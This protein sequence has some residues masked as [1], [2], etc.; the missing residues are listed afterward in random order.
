MNLFVIG[1]GG[2]AGEVIDALRAAPSEKMTIQGLYDDDTR[3]KGEPH[4]AKY[5]G[6]IAEFISDTPRGT[7]YIF[8]IGDNLVRNRLA[9]EFD[10]ASKVPVSVIHPASSVSAR[11]DI[12]P[13]AYVAAFAFVG[14]RAQ[15]GRHVIVNVGASVGHDAVLGDFGQLCPG[16]RV[17]G[18]CQ[19]GR[20]A[21]LGSNAVVAPRVKVGPWAKLSAGSF[22]NRDVP[23]KLFAIGVPAKVIPL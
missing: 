13:G 1:G 16:V 20:G 23:E 2:F 8:A 18:Y 12:G 9:E 22:A 10:R 3:L 4:G 19:V 5:C 21:F 6:T 11:A 14:P 15:L 17:S 7:N